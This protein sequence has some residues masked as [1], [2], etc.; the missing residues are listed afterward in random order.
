M[1]QITE[2]VAADWSRGIVRDAPRSAIP[3]SGLYDLVNGLVTLPGMIYKRGGTA[4]AGPALTGSSYAVGASY[5]NFT[6][7]G[8]LCGVGSNAHL[9]TVTSGATTD[10]ATLTAAYFTMYDRPKLRFGNRLILPNDGTGTARYYGTDTVTVTIAS[11]AV[12]TLAAHG[13]AAGDT[14]TFSTTG[15]LPT[16]LTA[17]TVYYVISTGLTTDTFRVSTSSG[18]S[19]VNTSGTQSGTH[20]VYSVRA[21][22]ASAPYFK[23]VD[24]FKTYVCVAGITTSP[25]AQPQRV[26]FS[27]TP[28]FASAWDT[29]Y[30]YWDFDNEVTGLAALQNALLVFTADAT[31][32]LVGNVAPPGSDFVAGPVG[33]VG[34]TDA[35][36]IVI[37]GGNAIFASP[38]GVYITNGVSPLDLTTAGGISTYWTS[39]F[40]G[41]SRSTWTIAAGQYADFYVVAIMN[42]STFVDCLACDVPRRAWVRL[43]NVKPSMFASAAGASQELYY[44]DRSTNRLVALGSAL[45]ASST[46]KNDADGSAVTWAAELRLIGNGPG[47]KR[48]G[49]GRLTYDMRDAAT[50][51][52]TLAVSFAENVTAPSFT[53]C[54]ESPLAETTDV[55]RKRFT[56]N[57]EAQGLTVK[58]AQSNASSLTRVYAVE[59]EERPLPYVSEGA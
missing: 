44:S 31:T 32:R 11:P 16:G 20:T 40:S 50:D 42:G 39:L 56:V 12:F 38:S 24:V 19:A 54:P 5:A 28:N 27:P 9:Y 52:P 41:Y 8:V 45:E 15:A 33:D 14:V 13:F 21:F 36:S 53:A 17:G 34:C 55:T 26:Y 22:P 37:T 10:V 4:Y 35:R 7:G 57:R 30:S 43:S 48:F 3:Q 47:L 2:S 25:S 18:G 58:L 51:D 6:S 1:A 59:V 29:T 46:A 49:H 23:Y